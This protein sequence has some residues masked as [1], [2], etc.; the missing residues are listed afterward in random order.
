MRIEKGINIYTYTYETLI[1]NVN[2]NKIKI[3]TKIMYPVD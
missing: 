2:I 1:N 3:R